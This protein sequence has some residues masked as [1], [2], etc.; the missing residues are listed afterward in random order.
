MPFLSSFHGVS[1]VVAR[2]LGASLLGIL[3]IAG[4]ARAADRPPVTLQANN[5]NQAYPG[6]LV[7]AT[8]SES[9]IPDG[10]TVLLNLEPPP[11][12][13]GYWQ[14]IR[15]TLGTSDLN[16]KSFVV[17]SP[18]NL[19]AVSDNVENAFDVPVKRYDFPFGGAA[20]DLATK[21]QV[22]YFLDNAG[23]G[24]RVSG[25]ATIRVAVKAR[26]SGTWK[27]AVAGYYRIPGTDDLAAPTAAVT[28]SSNA[29]MAGD[30]LVVSVAANA[31]SG[32]VA[33]VEIF[34]N[35]THVGDAEEQGSGVWRYTMRNVQADL[36]FIKAHVVDS[37]G[38][39]AFSSSAA[40]YVRWLHAKIN[41]GPPAESGTVLDAGYIRDT[42][43]TFGLHQG[44]VLGERHHFGWSK[45]LVAEDAL[46]RNGIELDER[47]DTY[48][49]MSDAHGDRAEWE[50]QVPDG[51]YVVQLGAGDS[52]YGGERYRLQIEDVQKTVVTTNSFW[53]GWHEVIEVPVIVRDG[54]LTIRDI[55]NE[56]PAKLNFVFI[57][58]TGSLVAHGY[59]RFGSLRGWFPDTVSVT[60]LSDIKVGVSPDDDE[61]STYDAPHRAVFYSGDAPGWLEEL[62]LTEGTHGWGA[63][64][65]SAV[66]SF[67]AE[68][69]SALYAGQ[70]YAFNVN[71][72]ALKP[73]VGAAA[74]QF[75]I[76]VFTIA[77]QYVGELDLPVN[78]ILSS[79]SA[80]WNQ[81]LRGG[82]KKSYE[83]ASLGL[84]VGILRSYDDLSS[85]SPKWTFRIS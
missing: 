52:G 13:S 70:T 63:A 7:T 62:G 23:A 48:A 46:K 41:F 3:L 78:E 49:K 12:Q 11:G 14:Y 75:R 74:P 80:G 57:R 21:G 76:R 61:I 45:D 67:G 18:E 65:A 24:G 34:N 30:D 84:T 53:S 54:R 85:V 33:R 10:D 27:Y 19:L 31:A 36:Q 44:V 59:S 9:S 43:Q 39:S 16:P 47:F 26:T 73:E 81:A 28:L 35:E 2:Y 32:S 20:A 56:R 71:A 60:A 83:S 1:R 51:R 17:Y 37:R 8:Q 69:G 82:L 22:I 50:I 38:R 42:G 25:P 66:A 6:Y 77:R 4:E 68:F 64:G 72:G 40:V 5:P 79:S 15:V 55:G 58:Q 29:M